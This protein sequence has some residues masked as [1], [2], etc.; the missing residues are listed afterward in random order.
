[1][2]KRDDQHVEAFEHRKQLVQDAG[3]EYTNLPNCVNCGGHVD[4]DTAYMEQSSAGL[5][6]W[7]DKKDCIANY[8]DRE[9]RVR[10]GSI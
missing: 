4:L 3:L 9:G 6:V 5:Q 1:M 10:N 8:T 2:A 7:C